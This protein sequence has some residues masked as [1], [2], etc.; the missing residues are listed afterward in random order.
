MN[1]K[2]ILTLV[3]SV[4]I[5][6]F[7]VPPRVTALDDEPYMQCD[8]GIVAPGDSE[9][10]V[11]EKCGEP[12]QVLRPDPQEPVVWV[13]NFGSTEFDYNISIVNGEVE[14]IQTGKYG[15]D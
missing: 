11:R 7:I 2:L 5:F 15:S 10:S 1:R 12:Q 3:L 4:L 13:Y 8:N 14:R 9:G 6:I